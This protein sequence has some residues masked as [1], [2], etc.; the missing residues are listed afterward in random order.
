MALLVFRRFVSLA[1]GVNC[2]LC[3]VFFSH[4]FDLVVPLFLVRIVFEEAFPLGRS[5]SRGNSPR[6]KA[7]PT[8]SADA[9]GGQVRLRWRGFLRGR[10]GFVTFDL[11]KHPEVRGLASH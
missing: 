3:L 8:R 6:L 11:S 10:G 9:C 2:R 4:G 5:T 7:Y 1:L